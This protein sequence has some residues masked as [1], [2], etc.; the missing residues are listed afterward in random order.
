MFPTRNSDACV[1][2]NLGGIVIQGEPFQDPGEAPFK[3]GGVKLTASATHW[4]IHG[5]AA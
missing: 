4:I 1:F 3:S 5:K 2:A